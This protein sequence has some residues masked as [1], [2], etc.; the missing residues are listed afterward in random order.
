[1]EIKVEQ[2]HID[3]GKPGCYACPIALALTE[4][5]EDKLFAVHRYN[6]TVA[7]R[8]ASDQFKTVMLPKV[9]ADFISVF[10]AGEPVEPFSFE[11]E[12]DK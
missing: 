7:T 10:D 6:V 1:M 11:F 12:V 4:S 3:R 8:F 5:F 2:H 9:A